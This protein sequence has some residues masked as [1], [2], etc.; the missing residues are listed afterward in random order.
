VKKRESI[1]NY[2]Y[3]ERGHS[4]SLYVINYACLIFLNT[5]FGERKGRVMALKTQGGQ[6]RRALKYLFLKYECNNGGQNAP[7]VFYC[8]GRHVMSINLM[9]CAIQPILSTSRTPE[10]EAL[11]ITV[12]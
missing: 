12:K 10:K 2:I 6:G 1:H 4:I 7:Q 3:N 8:S 5:F 9:P 11:Y